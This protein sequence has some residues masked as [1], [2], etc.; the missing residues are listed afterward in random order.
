MAEV[1]STKI[2]HIPKDMAARN[3][4]PVQPIVEGVETMGEK[5]LVS[6]PHQAPGR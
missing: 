3:F 5:R 4:H 2:L 6:N 1:I